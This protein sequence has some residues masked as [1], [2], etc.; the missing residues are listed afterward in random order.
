MSTAAFATLMNRY[1][2]NYRGTPLT[3][4]RVAPEGDQLHLTAT[5]N[6]LIKPI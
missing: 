3:D 2:F 4:L 1:V 5:L 6:K